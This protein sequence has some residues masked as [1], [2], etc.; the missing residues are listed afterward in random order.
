VIIVRKWLEAL[1]TPIPRPLP[2]AGVDRT[3]GSSGDDMDTSSD[4]E[5]SSSG[6]IGRSRGAVH[7]TIP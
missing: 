1:L 4:E 2:D 3:G 6:F 7:R 5:P